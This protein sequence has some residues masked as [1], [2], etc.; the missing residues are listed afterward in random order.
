[1]NPVFKLIMILAL[2][3][4]ISFTHVTALNMIII[5]I[6]LIYLLVFSSWKRIA[7]LILITCIPAVGIYV[8]QKIQG[9]PQYGILLVTRLY[10]FTAMGSTYT[11]K[12]SIADL[13]ASLEQNFNL[14]SKFAY[15]VMGAFNLTN[16]IKQEVI[17]IKLSA[18]MRN[19]YLSYWSPTLYFKAILAAMNWSSLLAQGMNSHLLVENHPR[20][21]Y[22]MIKIRLWDYLI[23]LIVLGSAQ[24]ILLEF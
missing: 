4:E 11:C 22:K 21:H 20:S 9:S 12:T 7:Y 1:M 5:T 16:T 14:P 19:I 2:A 10:A 15:G 6:S 13:A 24:I 3:L 23:L 8:A 18:Q 17:D